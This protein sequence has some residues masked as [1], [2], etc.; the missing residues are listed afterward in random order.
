MDTSFIRV[1]NIIRQISNNGPARFRPFLNFPFFDSED[2][3]YII[4]DINIF[5]NLGEGVQWEQK[6]L[7]DLSSKTHGSE[8]KA[9][10]IDIALFVA[11]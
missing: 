8:P 2:F 7:G 10:A 11:G 1:G 4:S 9:L 6:S 5:R 3:S